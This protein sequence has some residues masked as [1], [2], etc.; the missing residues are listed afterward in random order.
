MGLD[1]RHRY[2]Y[3]PLTMNSNISESAVTLH[4]VQP[5]QVRKVRKRFLFSRVFGG[6]RP[7][8]A[9]AAIG[10]LI[11]ERGLDNV[12][13]A[14]IDNCLHQYGVRDEAVKPLVLQ[15]WRHAVERFVATDGSL[16]SVEAAF[17]DRLKEVLGLGEVEANYERDSIL[18]ANFMDRA[19]PLINRL[20]A[21]YTPK[22][23]S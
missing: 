1:I 7:T 2:V 22:I 5:F 13:V 17:L 9:E 15:I 6:S 10:N 21:L 19:R 14:A 23:S 3:M 11:A 18:I 20:D 16:D 4:R 8:D 12:D